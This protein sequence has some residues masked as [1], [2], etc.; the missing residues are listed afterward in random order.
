MDTIFGKNVVEL[1]LIPRVIQINALDAT[2]IFTRGQAFHKNCYTW[3]VVCPIMQTWLQP[4]VQ[5]FKQHKRQTL[6]RFQKVQSANKVLLLH[7]VFVILPFPPTGYV[8][9]PILSK[10]K[11]MVVLIYSFKPLNHN[12]FE[13]HKPFFYCKI[14]TTDVSQ[15]GSCMHFLQ[16]QFK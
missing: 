9:C 3:D 6:T 2:L 10:F 12:P 8:G 7:S 14:R 11:I 1:T 15:N 5:L 4:P 16:D 13:T